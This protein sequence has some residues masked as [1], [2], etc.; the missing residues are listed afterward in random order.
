[1]PHI[2]L[3]HRVVSPD[4]RPHTLVIYKSFPPAASLIQPLRATVCPHNK[5]QMM[6]MNV[7]NI[8]KHDCFVYRPIVCLLH[9]S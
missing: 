7:T 3:F 5:E 4:P 8:D 9:T 2:S 1:L 6:S